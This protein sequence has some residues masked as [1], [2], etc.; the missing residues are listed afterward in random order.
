MHK[1]WERQC[2][3]RSH[4]RLRLGRPVHARRRWLAPLAAG[5][6]YIRRHGVLRV[7]HSRDDGAAGL[8]A[9]AN[10]AIT[11]GGASSRFFRRMPAGDLNLDFFN[12]YELITA[13]DIH[14]YSFV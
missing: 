10:L 8:M 3:V 14:E 1:G 7:E 9:R 13:E 6:P 11:R 5:R 2:P 12:A 4:R